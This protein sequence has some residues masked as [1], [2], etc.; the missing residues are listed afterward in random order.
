MLGI[1]QPSMLCNSCM[2]KPPSQRKIAAQLGVSAST[3]SRAL[4]QD[5]RVAPETSRRI[6]EALKTQGY[7]LDPVVSA[8]LSR[9]RRGSF[10]RETL[11]WCTDQPRAEKEWLKPLFDSAEEF[12]TRGGYQIEYFNFEKPTKRELKRLASIWQARGIRGVILGPFNNAYEELPFPW[13]PFAWVVLGHTW[14]NHSIHVVGRDFLLDI[15][16]G[17]DWLRAQGCQ[18]PGFILNRTGN[19]FLRTPL[20]QSAF[21]QYHGVS[22]AL[23][24]PFFEVKKDRPEAFSN[25]LQINQPDSL[26]LSSPEGLFDSSIASR[27]RKL[28]TVQLSVSSPAP[29]PNV[30]LFDPPYNSAGP[31]AV[32]ILHRLITNREF[33][34]PAY[35]QSVLLTSNLNQTIQG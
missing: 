33:G 30:L 26:V 15:R 24:Q 17:I 1:K 22:D 4:H 9:V 6:L 18:R 27:F 25:W 34:L 20:I 21:S 35:Q 19:P 7:Q 12:G 2:S 23:P 32:N 29:Q 14:V 16:N 10:Y 11:A 28:P 3:V 5:P 13:E 31:T 8:G